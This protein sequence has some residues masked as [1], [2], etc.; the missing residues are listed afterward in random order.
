[1]AEGET[2][3]VPCCWTAE[4]SAG[5]A[6]AGTDGGHVAGLA[7]S[8]SRGEVGLSS[9]L[10]VAGWDGLVVVFQKRR[11]A[12]MFRQVVEV[13]VREPALLTVRLNTTR[14]LDGSRTSN[15]LVGGRFEAFLLRSG[16]LARV[17]CHG[18]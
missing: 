7:G 3:C 6:E 1:M 10:A 8:G 17:G 11:T 16:W 9:R 14:P 12:Q 5:G 15:G 2:G 13:G 18:S 4:A